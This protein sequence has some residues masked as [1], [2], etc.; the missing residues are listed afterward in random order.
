MRELEEKQA[1]VF[2]STRETRPDLPYIRKA[3]AGGWRTDLPRDCVAKIESA[4]GSL[5]K[6]MGYELT[7]SNP[8]EAPAAYAV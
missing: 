8:A 3:K 6:D 4:W 5:M 2:S 1:H 7:V